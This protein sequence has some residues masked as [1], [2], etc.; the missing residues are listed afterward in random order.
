MSIN[1]KLNEDSIFCKKVEY[2]PDIC[3]NCY[4]RLSYKSSPHESY[5]KCV[6]DHKEYT[7]NVDFAYFDDEDKTGRP[8][9]HRSYCECGFVDSGKI[10]PL[11]TEELIQVS[12][13]VLDRFNEEEVEID[14][15]IFFSQVREEKSNPD[16]Q[17]NEEVILEKAAEESI[18]TNDQ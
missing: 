17:F 10:R 12:V 6:T 1:E 7:D 5:P 11:D 18:I 15:D 3:T 13:R 4:R 14:E 16:N 9:V 2:N 8:S